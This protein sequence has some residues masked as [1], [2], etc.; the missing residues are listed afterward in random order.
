M[1]CFPN[2]IILNFDMEIRS[3]KGTGR[4]RTN[5]LLF[6]RQAPYRLATA[7]IAQ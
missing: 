1:F 4:V 5:D 2:Y 6:T 7:P 3:K